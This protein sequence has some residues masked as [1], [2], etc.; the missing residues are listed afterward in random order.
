MP[1]HSASFDPVSAPDRDPASAQMCVQV[2]T[3]S[4]EDAGH[5]CVAL[6][7]KNDLVKTLCSQRVSQVKPPLPK[8]PLE[9]LLG[10][11]TMACAVASCLHDAGVGICVCQ[12][13]TCMRVEN[14]GNR[15]IY[16]TTGMR[17]TTQ[18]RRHG[19]QLQ[20]SSY[21][22]HMWSFIRCTL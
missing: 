15:A 13:E 7:A 22:C 5:S 8:E 16:C 11:V 19:K 20:L 2:V 4:L 3:E 6:L 1:F 17:P 21:L 18:Q 12:H 10:E 14:E 9:R